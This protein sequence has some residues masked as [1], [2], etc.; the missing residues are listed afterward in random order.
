[1]KQR[2]RGWRYRLSQRARTRIEERFGWRKT[3]AGLARTKLVWLWKL[4]EQLTL[5]SA[6]FNP[7]RISKLLAT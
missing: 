7:L 1:M 5:A 2:T 3:A 4:R 6:A